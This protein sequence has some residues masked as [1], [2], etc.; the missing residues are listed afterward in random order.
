[1]RSG[2]GQLDEVIDVAGGLEGVGDGLAAGGHEDELGEAVF[3]GGGILT[4]T[5]GEGEGWVLW[6]ECELAGDGRGWGELGGAVA[7]VDGD[8][9][10]G[11]GEAEFET[12]GGEVFRRRAVAGWCGRKWLGGRALGDETA[13]PEPCRDEAESKQEGPNPWGAAHAGN[14]WSADD[15]CKQVAER[16]DCGG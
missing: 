13:Q 11:G 16:R 6:V 7:S 5:D 8:F 3:T 14:V 12:G 10:G 4:P 15:K 1:M 2:D 9:G